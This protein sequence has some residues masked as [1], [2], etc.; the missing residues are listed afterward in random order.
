MQ[1]NARAI[2]TAGSTYTPI[3]TNNNMAMLDSTRIQRTACRRS[4]CSAAVI[5]AATLLRFLVP[6][7]G[8]F[9]AGVGGGVEAVGRHADAVQA[10][11][12]DAEVSDFDVVA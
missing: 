6:A 9:A 3:A 8:A 5:L 4:E 12:A 11:H 1:A 10:A 7:N 2:A